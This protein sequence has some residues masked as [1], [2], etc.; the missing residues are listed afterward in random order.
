[1]SVAE[2]LICG[3]AEI[4]QEL[5]ASIRTRA[6]ECS[7]EFSQFCVFVTALLRDFARRIMDDKRSLSSVQLTAIVQ[8]SHA[9]VY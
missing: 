3:D 4:C 1:M 6:A 9:H 8:V 7:G 2:Q 5:R